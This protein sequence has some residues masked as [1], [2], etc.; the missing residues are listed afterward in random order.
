MSGVAL[1]AA[2]TELARGEGLTRTTKATGSGRTPARA[3]TER[4]VEALTKRG[5][6]TRALL[7][8]AARRVFEHHGFVAARIRDISVAAGVAHGTFYT[9][10]DSKEAI[11][12]EV[13]LAM[14]AD[15][16]GVPEPLHD[17]E[18]WERIEHAN[19]VYME[20][21]HRNAAMMA[22][23]EQVVTFNEDIR[24]IRREVRRPFLD[25]NA[26]AIRRWQAAGLAD[27]NLDPWYA[28]NALG[29]M[30]DRFMYIWLVIGEPFEDD[31]ALEMLTRLWVQALGIPPPPQP[32]RRA[33]AERPKTAKKAT[34]VR[35]TKAIKAAP[36]ATKAAANATKGA[37][38]A[39]TSRAAGPTGARPGA[40]SVAKRSPRPA[41]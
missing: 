36:S 10:F 30:V 1:G 28:A 19:R 3:E 20:S 39:G 35:A 11:F 40:S 21:Y 33:G 4:D 37:P 38:R 16:A 22:T 18:P 31:I 17:A 25:R 26:R 6:R 24:N 32:T 41:G 9:Y 8:A 13:V 14:Q 5:Q 23:L 29:A 27:P 15:M 12:R 2:A 34:M 7:V